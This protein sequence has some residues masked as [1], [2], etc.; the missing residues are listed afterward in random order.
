MLWKINLHL[1][2]SLEKHGPPKTRR[3]SLPLLTMEGEWMH[4]SWSVSPLFWISKPLDSKFLLDVIV[5]LVSLSWILSQIRY[6]FSHSSNFYDLYLGIYPEAY[7]GV[8]AFHL[9]FCLPLVSWGYLEILQDLF[10]STWIL[11]KE[12]SRQIFNLLG[13]QLYT[14][15]TCWK[16]SLLLLLSIGSPVGSWLYCIKKISFYL[17]PDFVTAI[18][19]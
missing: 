9:Q 1:I 13:K 3:S 19:Y 14:F 4:G 5:Q 11:V 18:F 10:C 2:S 17:A 7:T 15:L 8:D 16:L 6:F 12:L